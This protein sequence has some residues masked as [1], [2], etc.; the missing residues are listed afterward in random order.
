M[1]Q[2]INPIFEVSEDMPQLVEISISKIQPNPNQPRK[3]LS[4]SEVGKLAESIGRVGLLSPIVVVKTDDPETFTLAA[5]QRRL[6]AYEK[7]ARST[8]PAI[9]AATG[10]PVE[11]AMIE[12][13]QRVDPNPVEMADAFAGMIARYNYTH[14]QIAEMLSKPRTTVT[15]WLLL[16]DLPDEI[17]EECRAL[18]INKTLLVALVRTDDPDER[19]RLWVDIKA[20][21]VTTREAQ[22]RQREGTP[23]PAADVPKELKPV[24]RAIESTRRVHDTLRKIRASSLAGHA[25]KLEELRVLHRQIGNLIT[26]LSKDSQKAAEAVDL[27]KEPEAAEA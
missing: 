18:D 11:L 19:Q 8:I 14:D 17:K 10:D 7:L 13:I 22:R 20:R 5:G 12:N 23:L 4:E 25:D 24:V 6:K 15:E 21:R 26:K 9:I 27:E 2:R 1:A 3:T 16:N